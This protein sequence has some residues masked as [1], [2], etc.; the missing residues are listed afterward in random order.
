MKT[1]QVSDET[2]KRLKMRA[3]ET[4][5]TLAA[6]IDAATAQYLR[7]VESLKPLGSVAEKTKVAAVPGDEDPSHVLD[8]L[9][10][11]AAFAPGMP[12]PNQKMVLTDIQESAGSKR[13]AKARG[14]VAGKNEAAAVCACGHRTT[15]HRDLT[16][17]CEW[18][19]G[20]AC[21]SFAAAKEPV[22]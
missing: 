12:T 2:W 16:G 21:R 22:F 17:K 8:S 3:A 7:V 18:G 4:G 13:P 11:A 5:L 14:S 6:L 19:P 10:E 9:K 20:C 1:V 15:S